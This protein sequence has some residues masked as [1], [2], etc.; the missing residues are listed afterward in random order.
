MQRKAQ[1]ILAIE[2]KG[3]QYNNETMKRMTITKLGSKSTLYYDWGLP[4]EIL[5][6]KWDDDVNTFFEEGKIKVTLG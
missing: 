6:C 4:S 1:I 2:A 3:L 5:I